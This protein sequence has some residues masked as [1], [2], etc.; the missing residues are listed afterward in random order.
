MKCHQEPLQRTNF[1]I[2]IKL[3]STVKS[4]INYAAASVVR[5]FGAFPTESGAG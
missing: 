2:A 1:N 5:G 3:F 4:K